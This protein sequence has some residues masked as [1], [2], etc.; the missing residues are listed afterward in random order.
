LIL[1]IGGHMDTNIGQRIKK[2]RNELH[3]TQTDIQESCGISSGNLSG[4]E[5][6]R[7]LPSAIAL[8]ALSQKLECSIDWILTGES[9][10]SKN[11]CSVEAKGDPAE[12]KLLS[13]Y[14]KM[15][16]EDQIELLMIAQI[17]TNKGKLRHDVELSLSA[18][19]DS[20]ETV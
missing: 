14:R 6:G 5:K 18:S 16:S 20:I 13:Y 12:E 7:Y 1:T 2:R 4:I 10:I 9:S 19:G 17:K 15:S 3:I 8:I 11:S